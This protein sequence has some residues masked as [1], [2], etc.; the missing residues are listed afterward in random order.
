MTRATHKEQKLY[1]DY[2]L[3]LKRVSS[4]LSVEADLGNVL[5]TVLDQ[6]KQALDISYIAIWMVEKKGLVIRYTY[7]F[8]ERYIRF[9]AA[10]PIRIGEAL[11]GETL[12]KG[13]PMFVEDIMHD[14]RV[15]K[16]YVDEL[17]KERLAVNSILFH[18]LL[19]KR[20]KLGTLA[21]YFSSKRKHVSH[22]EDDVF[23]IV[24]NQFEVFLE[25]QRRF[26]ELRA[27]KENVDEKMEELEKFNRVM[28][29]REVRMAELKEKI[30]QLE[31]EKSQSV[32]L[33]PIH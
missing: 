2:F 27:A 7:G 3:L 20:K 16:E 33:A 24:A 8:P 18:P 9:S 14:P 22:V 21:I 30:R 10:R 25:N 12:A 17:T 32:P 19:Y 6:M 26:Q 28:I 4:L 13:K 1:P 31:Q 5:K 15:P 29:G 11:V 23:S